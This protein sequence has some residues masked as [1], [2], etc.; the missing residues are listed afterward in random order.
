MTKKWQLYIRCI[1]IF[2]NFTNLLTCPVWVISSWTWVTFCGTIVNFPL[3]KTNL[4]PWLLTTSDICLDIIGLKTIEVFNKDVIIN[5][6]VCLINKIKFEIWFFLVFYKTKWFTKLR[7]NIII[8]L[9]KPLVSRPLMFLVKM[10]LL[11]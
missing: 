7:F 4:S 6:F 1:I 3:L 9:L 2:E 8:G 11:Y 5:K 10:T